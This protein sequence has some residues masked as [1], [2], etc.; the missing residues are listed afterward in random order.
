MQEVESLCDSAVIL[1]K[2]TVLAQG[3]IDSIL[4]A[5]KARD[6]SEAFIALSSRS[7]GETKGL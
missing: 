1:G 7:K 5:T 4:S 2:G 3:N 6:M